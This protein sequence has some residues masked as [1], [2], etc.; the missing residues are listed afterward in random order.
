MGHLY[1]DWVFEIVPDFHLRYQMSRQLVNTPVHRLQ[2]WSA[3]GQDRRVFAN[4][5]KEKKKIIVIVIPVP[6]AEPP[7]G[8]R[9]SPRQGKAWRF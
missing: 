1:I 6:D 5:L 4:G 3:G 8:E 7:P 9:K 2:T